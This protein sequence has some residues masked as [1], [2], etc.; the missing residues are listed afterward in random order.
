[1]LISNSPWTIEKVMELQKLFPM[2]RPYLEHGQIVL[3][4]YTSSEQVATHL[5]TL[6]ESFPFSSAHTRCVKRSPARRAAAINIV[7]TALQL[8]VEMYPVSNG[9]IAAPTDPV[10]SMIAVTVA[11]ARELPF[12]EL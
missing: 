10:P 4:A 3:E 1:L 6:E 12:N 11:S 8:S 2:H 7:K 9:P 5:L